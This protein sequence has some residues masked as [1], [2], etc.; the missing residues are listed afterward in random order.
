MP[1]QL[2]FDP[3]GY[4]IEVHPG[5]AT[6]YST[7]SHA[8]GVPSS[9]ST[10]F[11]RSEFADFGLLAA[12]KAASFSTLTDKSPLWPTMYLCCWR[13]TDL[14]RHCGWRAAVVL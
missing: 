4:I 7:V 2:N 3:G 14:A 9:Y 13:G 8:V 6:A 12:R 1:P 5:F 10:A 11:A